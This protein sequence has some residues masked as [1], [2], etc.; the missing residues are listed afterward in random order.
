TVTPDQTNPSITCP[1]AIT[2]VECGTPIE[3]ELP[4]AIDDCGIDTLFQTLGLESGMVFPE[5]TTA[6]G[7]TAIDFSGNASSC[8]FQ[9]TVQNTLEL[10]LATINTCIGEAMGIATTMTIT[11]GS[12]PYSIDWSNGTQGTY[13]EG[14]E[15]GM[16]SVTIT[17]GGGCTLEETFSIATQPAPTIELAQVINAT[18]GQNNGSIDINISGGVPPLSTL[19]F[20]ENGNLFATGEDLSG[21]PPGT[22]YLEVSDELGCLYTLDSGPVVIENVS[23]VHTIASL[24][25][26]EVLPN[27]NKGQF[28]VQWAFEQQQEVTLQIQDWSGRQVFQQHYDAATKHAASIDLRH[29]AAGLY[30]VRLQVGN[31]FV[32]QKIVLE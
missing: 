6:V 18:N 17:D 26:F 8:M 1:G 11:G 13:T 12:I 2:T 4:V 21:L 29:V 22:Y 16:H 30:L 25:A 19:W 23:S 24:A 14:L 28:Q 20:D 15:A 27:P 3:F 7:F 10:E 5:G 9:V 32:V 31:Q